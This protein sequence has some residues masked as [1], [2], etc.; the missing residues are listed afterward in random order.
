MRRKTRQFQ[1]VV[2][3]VGTM[4]CQWCT[5]PDHIIVSIFSRLSLADRYHASLTCS[6]WASCFD[7]R[8]LWTN[9]DFV[10]CKQQ[11]ERLIR[12]AEQRSTYLKSV[13][14]E[15][16]QS[17][18]E[19]RTNA[20]RVIT[21]L[22][23]TPER[24]LCKLRIKFTGENPLFYSSREFPSALTDLFGSN[25]GGQLTVVDL[26]GM[27]VSINDELLDVLSTNERRIEK[28]YVE[29]GVLACLVSPACLLRVVRRCRRLTDLRVF[30]C[31]IS[32]EVLLAFATDDR[33]SLGHLS[34]LCRRDQHYGGDIG[35]D[36]W[37]AVRK[38]LPDLRVSLEFDHTC[39]PDTVASVLKAEVPVSALRLETFTYIYDEVRQAT[40]YYSDTL[41]TLV[42]FTPISRNAPALNAA[43]IQLATRC[44]RLRALHVFCVL[45]ADTIDAI[46]ASHPVMK[47]NKTYTLKS[48]QGQQPWTGDYDASW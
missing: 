4:T 44:R 43:L 19:N 29:N 3:W 27:L 23:R 48:E 30:G 22:S 24:R 5:L 41:E 34:M 25:G 10:F 21:L 9:F 35:C 7:S 32:E 42:L 13:N 45:D 18:A 12:C 33:A 38:T 46:L 17:V 31:S 8:Y 16:D 36:A 40:N 14:I 6:S 20:C 2:F 28:L 37:H 47:R 11:D 1:S 39:A 26:R 15:L